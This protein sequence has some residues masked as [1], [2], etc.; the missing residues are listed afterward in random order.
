MANMK[1]KVE[2]MKSGLKQWQVA[3]LVGIRDDAFSRKL[4]HELPREEQ[5]RIVELIRNYMKGGRN[6]G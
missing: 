3:D 4:R 5:D 1:I 6:N 2:I